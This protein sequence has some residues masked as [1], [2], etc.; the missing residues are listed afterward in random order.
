M[1]IPLELFPLAAALV[2]GFLLGLAAAWVLGII[3]AKTARELAEELFDESEAQKREQVEMITDHLKDAFGSLS[4]EA[5]S[6]STEEFLKLARSRMETERELGS[7][8][9]EEKKGLIDRQLEAMAAR[10]ESLSQLVKELEK[11]RVEKFGELAGK[12][13]EVSRNAT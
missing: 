6:R 12:L 3:Q 7:R 13:Q 4:M 2:A 10:M 9:L 1:G 11:D 5:L 8:E